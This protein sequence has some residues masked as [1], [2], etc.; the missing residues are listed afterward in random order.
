MTIQGNEASM[1]SAELLQIVQFVMGRENISHDAIQTALERISDLNTDR[2][3][4]MQARMLN[5]MERVTH[6]E[7]AKLSAHEVRTETPPWIALV[8]M[9]SS[10]FVSCVSLYLV[11]SR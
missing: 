5:L 11:W 2:H 6:L 1:T 3:K 8:F 10:V 4:D 9:A 7:Q